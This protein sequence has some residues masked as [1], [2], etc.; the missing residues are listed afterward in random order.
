MSTYTYLKH[1][2]TD[3]NI[4]SITPTSTFGIKKVCGHIDFKTANVIVEYGPAT[5]VFIDYLLENMNTD[6]R[7]LAIETNNNFVEL[8]EKKF[9][10]SRFDVVNESAE[11]VQQCL[12]ARNVSHADYIISGIP[13]SFFPM[14]LKQQIIKNTFEA[15]KPGGKFLVYQFFTASLKPEKRLKTVLEEHFSEVNTKMEILNVPP[16]TIFEAVKH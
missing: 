12:E 1:F 3:R 16:L 5:G 6:A 11:H 14:Q 4:A 15:L 8:L 7:L 2:F 9:T 10:D 13:F